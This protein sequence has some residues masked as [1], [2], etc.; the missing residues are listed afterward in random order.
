MDV[1]HR[2]VAMVFLQ[3]RI[4]ETNVHWRILAL[5][6]GLVGS[7]ILAVHSVGQHF[8]SGSA[9][10]VPYLCATLILVATVILAIDHFFSAPVRMRRRQRQRIAELARVRRDLQDDREVAR[11]EFRASME[12][13]A[14][15]E[16]RLNDR[17][18]T[19]HEWMEFPQ[20]EA[21]A[22]TPSDDEQLAAMVA[23]D[24]ELFALLDA[25]TEQLFNNILQNKYVQQG[26]LQPLL[27]RQDAVD[28]IVKVSRIYQPNA[29]QPLLET[30]S[31]RI[32]RS[33]SRICLQMLVLLDRLPL[34][35]KDY[36]LQSLYRYVRQAVKAYGV[37]KSS[38]PYWSHLSTAYYL[39]RFAMGASP[40]TLGAWW[41]ISSIGKK[42]AT[43]ATTRMLNRQ[44][45]SLLRDLVRV[46]GFETA[47]IYAGDLRHRDANWIYGVELVELM[48]AVSLSPQ[49]FSAALREVGT[50]PLRSEYDRIFLYRC[51]AVSQSA[52]PERYRAT[53]SLTSDERQLVAKRLEAFL[54]AFRLH[55]QDVALRQ[56]RQQV[57]SR[58][59]VKLQLTHHPIPDVDQQRRSAVRSLAG[60]LLDVKQREVEELETLLAS[61]QVLKDCD[62]ETRGKL[63]EEL[64]SNPPFFFEHPELDSKGSLADT[65]LR[66]LVAISIRVAPAQMELD[67]VL[68]NAGAFLRREP[69]AMRKLL[70]EQGRAALEER[71]SDANVR[72]PRLTTAACRGIIEWLEEG[73]SVYFLYGRVQREWPQ[74]GEASRTSSDSF[75]LLGAGQ[76]LVL[77]AIDGEGRG[78]PIWLGEGRLQI[79]RVDSWLSADCRL[80]G[81]RWLDETLRAP[82]L[83]IPGGPLRKFDDTFGPIIRFCQTP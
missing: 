9:P 48:R 47:S 49:S 62:V 31:E 39:G 65:F 33:S 54:A 71:L 26:Q 11:R 78:T 20:P 52:Q 73:E 10:L 25:E 43:E 74:P 30:S 18:L 45:L 72:L 2:E 28:L 64:Q 14:S 7:L 66:D 59:D 13:L 61:R 3:P 27:M 56:W 80:R 12:R 15:R 68:A 37:Y 41:L 50:L 60:Y 57:E 23:K 24:R 55:G 53:I 17:L 4:I 29:E 58:L 32:L 67:L 35:V 6:L 70:E 1:V 83:L 16:Q 46:I 42:H 82:A 8:Q 36:N 38:E 77:L 75:W 19:F 69:A 34:N 5:V 51:L 79:E 40:M 44:A 81:G 63:F 21:V 22:D 76:R